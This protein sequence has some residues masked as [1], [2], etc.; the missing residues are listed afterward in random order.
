MRKTCLAVLAILACSL[1]AM[2]TP[3]VFTGSGGSLAA[4]VTF[5]IVGGNL[6][7]TLTNTGGDALVPADLL[8]AVFF[9]VS[10]V[11]PLT[12]ISAV[13]PLGSV[14]LNDAPATIVGGEWAY[15]SGLAG[16]PLG[17][18]E[19]LSSVGLTLFGNANFPGPN[20]D[21]PVAVAGDS[22]G[23][24]SASNILG[25]GNP[26]I[27]V[28]GLLPYVQSSVVFT[29][30][31]TGLGTDASLLDFEK[32]S[33]Q[34]G[35]SLEDPNLPGSPGTPIPEPG[36]AMLIGLGLASLAARRRARRP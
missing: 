2:A 12:P 11:G 32:V 3:V 8:T 19:G 21:G 26:Q 1:P 23:I 15:A 25:T 24:A 4:S 9:D 17:A 18:T 31:G 27:I 14:V 22:Y 36:T 7:V 16:A 35:S 33:F 34:Y 13:L 6:Q 5:D 20:L 28:P 30:S 10:G 29:L